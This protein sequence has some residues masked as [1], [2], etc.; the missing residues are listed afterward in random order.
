MNLKSFLALASGIGFVAGC[1]LLL[2]PI[3][4]DAKDGPYQIRCSQ[5]F[6]LDLDHARSLDQQN[7][8]G[9][10]ASPTDYVGECKSSATFRKALGTPIAIV[11][12]V[13]LAGA[14]LV[15]TPTASR[16][17]ASG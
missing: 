1:L 16:Q 11:G 14:L 12:L 3:N 15:K 10:N 7:R 13:V 5:P 9:Y 8:G 6:S 17:N 2:L 4:I